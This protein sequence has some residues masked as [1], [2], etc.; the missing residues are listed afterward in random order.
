[1]GESRIYGY[2]RVSSKDQ[3]TDRQVK[4]L[5]SYGVEDRNILV[6]KMSGKNFDRPS[7]ITLKNTILRSGDILVI[8][9]LDR[10]GRNMNMVKSEWQ[11]LIKMGVDII[12]LD[13]PILN[14]ANKND[15]EK[16]LISNIVFELLAYMSEKERL[17]IRQRQQEGINMLKA[18][19]GGKGIGR[20]KIDFPKNWSEIYKSWK[21]KEITAKKAMQELNLK[22]STFYDMVKKYENRDIKKD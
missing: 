7:Y 12:V 15:L 3:N 10:L 20:P 14:T 19:N 1:M 13:T 21:D 22:K 8:K 2:V 4:A 9:E 11:E 17:K 16:N 6:D 5:E 18:K